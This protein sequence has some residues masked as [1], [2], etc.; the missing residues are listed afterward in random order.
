MK[1]ENAK[2]ACLGLASTRHKY[3]FALMLL[4]SYALCVGLSGC[5]KLAGYSNE[6][7]FP[8]EVKTVCVEMFDNQ[9][10]RRG[11]EY[12]LTDALAKRIEADTPYKIVS[13]KDR[14]DT[15]IGGQITSIGESVITLE[16]ETGGVLEKETL[17]SAVVNWK[18]LR[19]GELLI[20][21]ESVTAS[22]TYSDYQNQDFSYSSVL[23]ANRL[24]RKIVQLMEEE[25]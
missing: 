7:L 20:D 19:T 8:E 12:E 16:R 17:V 5:F 15:V 2:D 25:W 9:T 23:A 14:A 11:V 24:A 18:N 4:C 10:F 6:S 22:A 1:K 3:S 13:S 21:S